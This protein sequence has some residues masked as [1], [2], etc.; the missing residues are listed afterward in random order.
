M[1]WGCRTASACC[2][3]L[4]CARR[5]RWRA[6]SCRKC[7]APADGEPTQ[8]WGVS[9]FTERSSQ[10]WRRRFRSP[11]TLALRAGLRGAVPCPVAAG[12][13]DWELQRRCR[14]GSELRRC[15][16][17]PLHRGRRSALGSTCVVRFTGASLISCRC[18]GASLICR[19]TVGG[20]CC[21]MIRMNSEKFPAS[22]N[23]WEFC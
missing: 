6:T 3:G 4:G 18:T 11:G 14:C 13:R 9:I 17:L 2:D 23:S 12:A 1:H 16:W 21:G 22:C 15:R 7:R 10:S 8:L 5:C 20:C 19:C